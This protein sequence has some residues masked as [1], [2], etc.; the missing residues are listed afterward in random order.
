MANPTDLAG[1]RSTLCEITVRLQQLA[2]ALWLQ[3]DD[4]G[5]DSPL[6]RLALGCFL[7]AAHATNLIP[8]TEPLPDLPET[9]PTDPAHAL[10]AIYH[11]AAALDPRI[12]GGADLTVAIAALVREA[13]GCVA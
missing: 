12:V 13:T 5:L 7:A 4:A 11:R 8:T 3:A 6:H 2:Q 9:T 1:A 10:R